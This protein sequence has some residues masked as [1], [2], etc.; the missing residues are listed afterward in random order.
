MQREAE[1]LACSANAGNALSLLDKIC[2]K[3]SGKDAEFE[4]VD[5]QNPSRVNPDYDQSTN[6]EAALGKLIGMAFS[7]SWRDYLQDYAGLVQL[8]N[9]DTLE[10][11]LSEVWYDEALLKF[12]TRY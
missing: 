3:H 6:P 12:K 7:N 9:Q 2:M 5:L 4:A 8:K 11:W 10:K 1:T